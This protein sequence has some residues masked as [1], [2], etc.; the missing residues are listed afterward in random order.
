MR[1][2]CE[3][4]G[5]QY[6]LSDEKVGPKGVK[7]RCKKCGS[8][9][10]VKRPPSE[11]VEIAPAPPPP[12]VGSAP[13]EG[14]E[15]T[16]ERELGHAFDSAFGDG[17]AAGIAA[18]PAPALE[19]RDFP[20]WAPPTEAPKPADEPSAV[21]QSASAETVNDWYVA[22]RDNQVGPM[23]APDVK[24]RWEAGEIG[25]DTLAWRPGMSDWASI[26]SIPEMTEYLAPAPR[27]V[28]GPVASDREVA[29]ERASVPVPAPASPEVAEQQPVELRTNGVA[30]GHDVSW[31]PSAAS[32]LAS[33]A[34]EEISSLKK[35][36][37]KE[38]LPAAHEKGG[39]L[40]DRM[41][42]PESGV[43]PTNVLPLQLKGLEPTGEATL[44]KR[45]AAPAPERVTATAAARK[46]STHSAIGVGAV[47]G[48]LCAVF[49]GIVIWVLRPH[50][51]A[52]PA[53]AGRAAT[54]AAQSS[55]SAESELPPAPAVPAK[56][57]PPAAP[58]AASPQAAPAPVVA[59]PAPSPAAPP[60]A[61]AP[62]RE[63]TPVASRHKERVEPP[64]AKAPRAR[65]PRVAV[66][67]PPSAQP[68]KKRASGDPLL[69]VGGGDD[70]IEK[71]FG[72]SKA[73]KRSVYVPPAIGSD[74]PDNV[75]VSQI[76]EAVVGQK[77]ALMRCI[78]RQKAAD[79]DTRG[80]LRMRWTITGEGAV[81]DVRVVSTEYARQ[82]IAPCIL[83]V[84]R[85]LR[86][87]RSRTT[88]QDVVFPFKF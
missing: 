47:T 9:V 17:A 72:S 66:Q 45:A 18:G 14:P 39:S 81:R 57:P 30:N 75:S 24:A 35:P 16:L 87:P 5:A 20:G 48:V 36:E 8:I 11:A 73:S 76:N 68:P 31:K 85:A 33:L 51:A 6:M 32:A 83:G 27:A 61:A 42:L 26:A 56:L 54:A 71:E 59:Q 44:K 3:N 77:S 65:P 1:F 74:L 80:T 60:A 41:D 88:G 7:V 23:P 79:P 84:V 86:F 34:N 63:P 2:S 58:I 25:P 21:A 67:E 70:E 69:D 38:V 82:P 62:A 40:V 12:A 55:P 46:R 10:A 19:A 4:C 15:P 43:D 29:Q 64:P 37:Q 78:D 49:V 53:P 28:A 22:I 52:S 50:E 13:G